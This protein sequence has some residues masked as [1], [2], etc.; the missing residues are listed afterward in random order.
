M[1]DPI[2][3]PTL[4]RE[5]AGEVRGFVED[6]TRGMS[7]ENELS[8][9]VAGDRDPLERHAGYVYVDNDD[10]NL[11]RGQPDPEEPF[12][13]EPR[14]RGNGAYP[15]ESLESGRGNVVDVGTGERTF[16]RRFTD[17]DEL[18]DGGYEY[19]IDEDVRIPLTT[20][21]SRES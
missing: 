11:W 10:S 20:T 3:G 19:V 17:P 4:V 9:W 13:F 1:L 8:I 5:P 2:D 21:W 15:I 18:E 6:F 16:A 7:L 14:G 12:D